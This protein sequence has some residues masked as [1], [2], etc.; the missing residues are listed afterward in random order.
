MSFS[1]HDD[2]ERIQAATDIVRLIGEHVQLRPKGRELAGLCPFHDD[3]NPS[4]FV[5]PAKQIY[6]CFSC[7][8][9]GDCF[10]FAMEYHKLDF[11]EALKHLADR[12]GLELTPYRPAPGTPGVPG[13]P[14]TSTGQALPRKRLLGANDQALAFFRR[15]LA[16]PQRGQA[17]RDYLDQRGISSSMIEQFRIGYAPESW[18]ALADTVQ[19]EGGDRAAFEKAGLIAPAKSGHGDYDKFRHRLMF[20]ICDDMGRPV[21]FGGRVLPGGTLDDPTRDAKYLNSPESAIFNKSQT[22]YGLDL[23]K[24]PIIDSK[25]AVIV[26]GYTD[27]IACHQHGACN[28]VAALGT[29]FTHQHAA[30][31]R[32]F[33][34]TVVLVFDGDEAGLKAADRAVEVLMASEVDVAIVIL[35]DGED[36][37]TLLATEGGPGRWAE[38]IEGAQGAMAYLL[39]RLRGDLTEAGTITGRQA[40]STEFLSRLARQGLLSMSPIRRALVLARVGELLHLTESAVLEELKRLAPRRPIAPA[41]RETGGAGGAGGEVGDEYLSGDVAQADSTSTMKATRLAE[42]QLIGCLLRCNELFE[43]T[44]PDGTD[45]CEAVMAGELSPDCRLVYHM[46][47]DRLSEGR[48]VSLAGLLGD[49]AEAGLDKERRVVTSADNELDGREDQLEAVF[50]AAAL[51]LYQSRQDRNYAASRE[52]AVAVGGGGTGGAGGSPGGGTGDALSQA[53]LAQQLVEQRRAQA[54]PGRIARTRT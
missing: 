33:C 21:A 38:L 40:V 2:K 24:K 5:S 47:Y 1:G 39:D 29:A 50:K 45:F 9:G 23:A 26:E 37:D 13:A 4:M 44:L 34:E 22:L 41:V 35:P 20:P 17:V 52:A 48:T 10:T 25:Q 16:D 46:I 7:G 12:A 3:K 53:A 14:G 27:V 19:A 49:L 30:R 54:S 6:K 11:R 36:P 15:A 18:N 31:L 32:R 42:R 43:H 28:V 51:A 8:A